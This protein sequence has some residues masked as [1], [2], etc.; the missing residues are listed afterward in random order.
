MK[1]KNSQAIDIDY[2]AN[3]ARIELQEDEKDT[4][5]K[6]LS[7]ILH[8]I[9]QLNKVD[10]SKVEPMAHAFP[11]YNVWR[12]DKPEASF[13]PQEALANAPEQRDQQLIV[14]KVVE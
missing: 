4:F 3:L 13:T 12:E 9:E 2:V 14:P 7:D 5:A 8:Y 10:V 6:Q 1:G 11:V